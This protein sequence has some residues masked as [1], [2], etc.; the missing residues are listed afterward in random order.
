MKSI[1][2]I[3]LFLYVS[4]AMSVD[5]W[6][7]SLVLRRA[8][9][10]YSFSYVFTIKDA[11]DNFAATRCFVFLTE[12]EKQMLRNTLNMVSSDTQL[13]SIAT[14]KDSL[15][16]LFGQQIIQ[17]KGESATVQDALSYLKPMTE[18]V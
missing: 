4:Y 13:R 15:L 18:E 11:Q 8:I 3:G 5:S 10:P 6:C 14:V 2:Q 7:Q 12:Q 16:G 17:A 9:K 1:I